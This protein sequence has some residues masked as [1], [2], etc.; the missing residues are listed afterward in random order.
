M[1][2]D[3]NL[4]KTKHT[5]TNIKTQHFRRIRPFDIAPVTKKKKIKK[6]IRLGRADIVDH[7]VDLLIGP[8]RVQK[9]FVSKIY[10]AAVK[11]S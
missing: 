5:F 10:V 11:G 6:H 3:T 1:S 9:L 8:S 2:P 4:H 7:S